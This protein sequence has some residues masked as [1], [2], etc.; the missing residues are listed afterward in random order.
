MQ[1]HRSPKKKRNKKNKKLYHKVSIKLLLI[2]S[3]SF[4]L[5][6]WGLL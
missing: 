4:T 3:Y 6:R 2:I 5:G 1:W